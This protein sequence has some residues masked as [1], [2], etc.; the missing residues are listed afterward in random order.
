MKAHVIVQGRAV[1]RG[2]NAACLNQSRQRRGE[3]QGTGHLGDIERLDAEPITRRDN[4]AGI[5]FVNGESEHAE[6]ARNAAFAPCVPC[7]ENDFCVSIGEELV[8][9]LFQLGAQFAE[10]IDAAIE[11]QRQTEVSI[12]HRL[13]RFFGKI[14]DSQSSMPEADIAPDH[15]PGCIGPARTEYIR[16][17]R[18]CRN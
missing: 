7:L 18:D 6:K 12:D 8:A 15:N 2:V 13:L 5:T 16:H 14:K 4:P 9:H 1:Y 17:F 11:H 3:P 10:I